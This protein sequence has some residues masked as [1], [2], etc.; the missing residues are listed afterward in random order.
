MQL[1]NLHTR[2][3]YTFLSSTI[4]LDSLIKFALENNLKTLVITD[5]NSMFGVPKF[6]KLCKQNK[7]NPVIGLEIEIENFNFILLA[8]N[9]SG[10][11]I[12]SEFSSKKTKK[13]DLFLTDLAEKDDIIIVDHPKKGFY[14]QKK[15][16][17]SKLFGEKQLKN[18]YIVENNPKIENAVYL[19]ERNL[20]FAEE[21]IYLE[22]LSKIKGTTLD[23][24][25]KFFD[26]NKWE[27][28]IDPIIIKRTNYL[29][30]NIQIQFP[31]IDFNLPDL[32]H[33]NGLESDLL[34]KKILK[35]AVQNRRIELSNYKWK[36]R[37]QYEYETICKLKFTNYFLIIWDFLK[38]ARKNEILIGPGRGSASGS[39]V[40]YLLEI[41][42]V[43]PLKY[44][45]IFERFLNPQRITMPD[46]D[47]DIQDTRRQEVIDYLFEKYGP[48][49]CAT[50]ITFST[51]AAKCV[52]RDIS[53]IFGIPEIQINK[54]AKLIPNNANLSQLYNQKSSEF[55]RLIEKG[56]NFKA[57]NNSEIYKK[58]YKI[59]AFL[60]GMPRQ[61]S[62]HAAGI[63]LSKIPIT[64]LVP[65][66]NSK[67][68]LNQI[69]YAAEF[70]ED[71]SLLKI[72]LLG[73]KNLTIVA[74]ILAKINSDGH[75][76]TFNQLPISENSTNNL[77]SQGKTSGIFQLESPGMTAS[78]KKIGVSSINDIIAIIS[79]FR[80][81]PIQQIPTYAKNKE[82]NN[83]EKIF[84][85][86]DKIVESTF[87]V[88][89]YQEQ[90]MQICQVVA[91]FNLEQADIIRVAISK[92]DETKLDKIKENFIKNGTNL[93]YEPKLVEH[94]YNLIYKFSDYGF[95]KAH[96]V[97]Y[98]TLAYKMAYLKAKYPAYFFVEL[99][100]NENGAQAKIKKH[101]GEARNFGFKIH[102][103]NINF[104][105]ENAVFDKGKNTIFL[106]LLMV[107]GLGT[108]A[109]KTIIDERSK[110]GIY[111]NFLDFIKRMKLVNFS[112]VAIEKLIFANTL[113]DFGNQETLAHN[114]ELLWNHA[115]FVLNDKDGNLVLTTDNFGL[116]LEF[117]EKIP[118]NQEKNYENEVKYLGM[119]FVD[120]QNNYL[121]TNQIRLKDLRIGNEYRLIL[122]LKNV[123]RL[124]KA[125]SE[126]FMVILADDENEIKI[127]TKN[128]DYLLLETKK[129]YEF[130]VFF[131]KPGKFYLK[132][133]PKNC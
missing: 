85:E 78:I 52:F 116:D 7:I 75:K 81:G 67:E 37:L 64:K 49:H 121:F 83:W 4:K 60:E 21:K 105:T 107:K 59:S 32:D 33:K 56:D 41:T 72:D 11:V 50:I 131:S 38:W 26:F 90:I 22:A 46:I 126:Y 120:D 70:I 77:L 102:R 66:H 109:I 6:Y 104:S 51:L 133:S 68:N 35:E 48:D 89:I 55:R 42:S 57:E 31:K 112:K 3:E 36:A 14:A 99:I 74:N 129:H 40:A 65:V 79:L 106:P 132:G 8:K 1:I 10:Y 27:Q 19:Q 100:S 12:L 23:S 39:L 125:N 110:N 95:N 101:V 9:Y 82:R 20:L 47:I 91:G 92:K 29:V 123:I 96:A 53:K 61:S 43:N 71:F 103:P 115:S 127:F 80:P 15:E 45:L 18:Y 98:A 117:L 113:S 24:S 88:I 73:L 25:T 54:N 17:L 84:P 76:I 30:E 16:Q 118:Y 119:S 13:K 2:T 124:R 114:F 5:L 122:E 34:L 69:Q 58:I 62:T 63:V 44:G 111:K 97:A 86:Y 130:I 28:E 108:I 128:P 94:I 87:G 93:G